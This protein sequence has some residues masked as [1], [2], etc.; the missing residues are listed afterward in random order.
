MKKSQEIVQEIKKITGN[1]PKVIAKS[2]A[3]IERKK[4][5]LKNEEERVRSI[6]QEM[7]K[8]EQEFLS[9]ITLEEAIDCIP[10]NKPEIIHVSEEKNRFIIVRPHDLK[11]VGILFWANRKNGTLWQVSF[12]CDGFISGSY[13]IP[14]ACC[15]IEL[16]DYEK[17]DASKLDEWENNMKNEMR[18]AIVSTCHNHGISILFMR[19]AESWVNRIEDETIKA[20]ELDK[21]KSIIQKSYGED[22]FNKNFSFIASISDNTGYDSWK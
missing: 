20:I 2:K 7:K 17:P 21:C 6:E 3:A 5:A 10:S 15:K 1:K 16:Y 19:H 4:L 13:S 18:K 8:A 14:C 11:N 22:V 12:Q 9:T